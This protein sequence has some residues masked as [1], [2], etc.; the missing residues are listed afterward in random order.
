MEDVDGVPEFDVAKQKTLSELMEIALSMNPTTRKTWGQAVADAYAYE[1][2]K[3][4]YYPQVDGYYMYDRIDQEIDLRDNLV[5]NSQ[6]L[7][8]YSTWT[9]EL[10]VSYLLLDF[11]GREANRLAF[12]MALYGS[13]FAHAQSIQDVMELVFQRYFNYMGTKALLSA[14]KDDLKNAEADLAAAQA[15]FTAGL[16][17]KVDVLQAQTVVA[18]TFYD[19]ENLEGQVK[20]TLGSLVTAIGL[21]ADT[22]LDLGDIPSKFPVFDIND[23][24]DHL[25]TLAK[26][27]RADLN[28]FR[29]IYLQSYYNKKIAE[30]QFYPTLTSN[31][32]MQALK[33]SGIGVTSSHDYDFNISLNIPIFYGF[34]Q[35]YQIKN[36]TAAMYTAYEAWAEKEDSVIL[37]VLT[38]YYNLEIA[39]QQIKTAEEGLKFAEEAYN[40]TYESYKAGVQSFIDVLQ[41][42]S[43][44][45][46]ARAKRIVSLTSYVSSLSQL[47]YSVGILTVSK[48]EISLEEAE[49]NL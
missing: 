40:V 38:A 44:L 26:I 47:A 25:I 48:K 27:Q 31:V 23:S 9:R 10:N 49:K 39:K 4:A 17:T 20:I 21:P 33:Y 8:W 37:E 13:N 45:S 42:Q 36:K 6:L 16:A 43:Q 46:E 32:N 5:S 19:L 18:N 2:S 11:G 7:G 30:S 3:S 24:L 35:Y 34:G 1:G 28:N 15:R 41:T 12:K 22:K 29:S 14:K